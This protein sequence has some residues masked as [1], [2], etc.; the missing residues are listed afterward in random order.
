M[1][2]KAAVLYEVNTPLQVEEIDLAEPKA[3]EVRVKIEVCGLCH[4]DLHIMRGEFP[5]PLPAVLGHEGA[6][7]VDTVG[8]GVTRVK[9][10]DRVL[11]GVIVSCGR[12]GSCGTGQP[13]WC[14]NATEPM[15]MGTLLDGTSRL[16]KEG[17]SINHIF[18]Q[19]AFA[20]YVVV[21]ETGVAKLSRTAPLDKICGLGCGLGTGL[22]AVINN[23]R[24]R[25]EPGASV[26]VL[27]CGSVGLSVIMGAKL[28]GASKI[29]AIDQLDNK[30]RAATEVGATHTINTSKDSALERIVSEIGL[31]DFAF[32]CVGKPD[33]ISQSF[34]MIKSSG[35]VVV[36]GAVPF[37]SL[38]PLDGFSFLMGK[39]VI[40]V[41]AGFMRPIVDMPRYVNLYLEGKLP[42][43]SL[44]TGHFKLDN[45]NEAVAALEKGEAIKSIILP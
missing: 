1:K 6:G 23:P 12:C 4:S 40:G 43:D 28:V 37:G 36:V 11:M 16:S 31:V 20:E 42:L 32:E 41:P 14:E 27:G 38:V 25:V 15:M 45:I 24:I 33:L 7:T 9:P 39:S 30:L 2:M 8:P 10:G 18:C 5:A 22:G 44:M 21:P 3:G 19:S 34:N 26:A 35:A 13:Y 17:Q 29:V